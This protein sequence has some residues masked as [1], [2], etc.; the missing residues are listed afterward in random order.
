MVLNENSGM[1]KKG[2]VRTLGE[3]DYNG[4]SVLAD[5]GASVDSYPYGP[6]PLSYYTAGIAANLH[7]EIL[8]AAEVMGVE[9]DDV[10]V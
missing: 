8:N 5:E 4:W 1:L 10:S 6:S 7:Q 3:D 9:L 2:N